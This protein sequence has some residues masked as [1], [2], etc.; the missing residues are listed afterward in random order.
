MPAACVDQC[1]PDDLVDGVVPADVLAHDA[2]PGRVGQRCGVH[3]A[4][5]VEH[6]LPRRIGSGNA[7]STSA[8]TVHPSLCGAAVRSGVRS[9]TSALQT[10]H[11]ARHVRAR[12]GRAHAVAKRDVHAVGVVL[13][14]LPQLVDVLGARTPDSTTSQPAVSSRSWPGVRIRVASAPPCRT[15]TNGAST[16]SSSGRVGAART[17]TIARRVVVTANDQTPAWQPTVEGSEGRMGAVTDQV[18]GLSVTEPEDV[19]EPK[20]WAAGIPSV[21]HA[22]QYAL[23]EMGAART[24][25]TLSRLNHDRRFRLPELRVARPG[26]SSQRGRVLRERRQGG[27]V[28][29]DPQTGRAATS[30]PP[31]RSPNCASSPS[32]GWSTTAGSPSRCTSRPA[33]PTTRRSGWDEAFRSSRDRLRGD[34]GPE[35]RGLL[36]Q[37]PHEQRGRVRLPAA[38]APPRDEQPAGLL[39]HVPRVQRR[40]TRARRSASARARSRSTTSPS[41]PS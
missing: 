13:A 20:T 6:A 23:G 28:G 38:R 30:S 36:H 37:R 2:A 29:G 22:M 31:T 4:A 32:T 7:A 21:T 9:S 8:R 11:A 27:R 14:T 3:A 34:A 5:A 39:Q 12:A 24:A 10:P 15:R 26:L 16:A 19:D 25:R 35:P 41:T 33:R 18:G 1:P 40:G 17:R